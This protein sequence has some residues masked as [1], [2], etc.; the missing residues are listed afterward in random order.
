MDFVEL[1]HIQEQEKMAA[2]G[3]TVLHVGCGKGDFTSYL[4][5]TASQVYAIDLPQF[6]SKLEKLEETHNNVHVTIGSPL[7][8]SAV[9]VCRGDPIDLLVHTIPTAFFNSVKMLEKELDVV[10]VGGKVLMEIE[11]DGQ[12]VE[13]V[14]TSATAF[15]ESIGLSDLKFFKGDNVLYALGVNKFRKK[16][17]DVVV[18]S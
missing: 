3:K 4:S 6:K 14:E 13:D 1:K 2:N 11:L 9:K 18:L 5:V 15:L 12:R 17:L 16:T 10:K 7:D 8:I